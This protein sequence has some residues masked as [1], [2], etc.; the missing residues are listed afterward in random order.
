M[1]NTATIGKETRQHAM[2][3]LA[4]GWTNEEIKSLPVCKDIPFEKLRDWRCKINKRKNR[5]AETEQKA[6]Q[7]E[8]ATLLFE[9]ATV[10]ATPSNAEEQTAQHQENPPQASVL[11][12]FAQNLVLNFH[13]ADLLFYFAVAIGCNGIAQALPVIGKPIAVVYFGVAAVALQGV[14]A[15]RGLARLPHLLALVFVEAVG[16]ASDVIWANTSLWGNVRSLP[17]DIWENK[18]KNGLGE[19]VHLWGGA[20]V[21]KPFYVACGVASLLLAACVY[22][23][24]VAWQ[25][26]EAKK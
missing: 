14:K 9:T 11:R 23:C 22:A 21:D 4:D 12:V 24:A 17:F 10:L 8:K 3:L 5:N 15:L 2:R 25:G 1:K 19:T 6:T 13:P 7:P 18:Y 16:F 26:N 20:D